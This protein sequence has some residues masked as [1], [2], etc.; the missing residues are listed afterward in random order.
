MTLQ[1]LYRSIDGSYDQALR[2]MK[3]EKLIGRHILKLAGSGLSDMLAQAA[4]SMDP[5]AIF[6]S[7]HAIKGVG[8]NLGLVRLSEQA[9]ELADEFRP[10]ASRQFSDSEAAEKLAA[11]SELLGSTVEGIRR[12][13]AEL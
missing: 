5:S 13:E 11:L 12:Y 3:A 1:E 8:A 7:T 9:S 4:S 10:G 2:V 6:E